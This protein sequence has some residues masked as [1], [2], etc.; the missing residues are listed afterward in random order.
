VVRERRERVAA[1][2]TLFGAVVMPPFSVVVLGVVAT[3][4]AQ[5]LVN[6]LLPGFALVYGV[7][8]L[9]ESLTAA[10]LGGLAL[11]LAGVT[12]ASSPAGVGPRIRRRRPESIV[13]AVPCS[14]ISRLTRARIAW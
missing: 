11:I 9:D 13:R 7:A 14:A 8:L 4:V 1:G 10:K 3:G 2:A 6:Y 5:L 12:L